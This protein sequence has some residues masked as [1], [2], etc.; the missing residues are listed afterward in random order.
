MTLD[1]LYH[2]NAKKKCINFVFFL[3]AKEKVSNAL[4]SKLLINVLVFFLEIEHVSHFFFFRSHIEFI[5]FI[6]IQL[7]LHTIDNLN[8]IA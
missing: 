1:L 5:S 4:G 8:T 7:N 2:L 6:V 3:H